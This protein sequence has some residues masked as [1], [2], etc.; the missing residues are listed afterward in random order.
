MSEQGN[1]VPP[2]K[3]KEWS[4]WVQ[5]EELGVRFGR[6]KHK[7]IPCLWMGNPRRFE[8]FGKWIVRTGPIEAGAW[9]D[10]RASYRQKGVACE[11]SSVVVLLT[12]LG[13]G[14]VGEQ[15][16]RDYV[17]YLVDEGDGWKALVEHVRAPEGATGVQIELFLRFTE[18]GQVW[19]RAVEMQSSSARAGRVVRAAA[20]FDPTIYRSTKEKILAR[21][22]VLI[23]KVA[24]EKPDVICLTEVFSTRGMDRPIGEVAEPI[25]G[26]PSSSL[27]SKKARQ[28]SCY[29]AASLHEK[30]L[31]EDGEVYYNT[32]V[33]F[34]RQGGFVGKYRK[35]QITLEEAE[36]Y[37]VSPGRD[38]PV[39]ETDFG[40]VG[41]LICW[42]HSFGELLR[43]LA[44]RGA[45]MILLAIAGDGLPH[46]WETSCRLHAIENNV[47]IVGSLSLRGPSLIMA[48]NGEILGQTYSYTQHPG[49]DPK[50]DFVVA[51]CDMD[52]RPEGKY[53]SVG[54]TYADRRSTYLVER[55]LD[56]LGPLMNSETLPEG[57]SW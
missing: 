5:R 26:G 19:W 15:V 40:K 24:Q 22:E 31:V 23:D 17:Q 43:I 20:V 11:R 34:D 3:S 13:K 35:V 28:Y 44:L 9:Y 14:I 33:L 18:R 39:F 30:V 49:D 10:I 53:M 57:A 42:D 50:M 37:R 55:R 56:V 2:M 8:S 52:L 54:D 32:G 7:G 6:R 4:T 47:H 29:I 48:P 21:A 16:R 25:P 46:H 45:E 1:I 36:L 51:E 27:L 41:I 12:W 38:L